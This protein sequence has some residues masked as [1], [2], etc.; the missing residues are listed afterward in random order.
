MMLCIGND[1]LIVVST[2]GWDDD[3]QAG[4][5]TGRIKYLM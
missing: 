4:L 3:M 2:D 1:C 5:W